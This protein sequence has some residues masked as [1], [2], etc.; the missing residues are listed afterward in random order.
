MKEQLLNIP[1]NKIKGPDVGPKTA[2]QA[3]RQAHKT[4]REKG[5]S[6]EREYISHVI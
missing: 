4:A 2:E 3:R 1:G 5:V 6:I